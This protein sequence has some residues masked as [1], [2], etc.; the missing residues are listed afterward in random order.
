MHCYGCLQIRG[1]K[2]STRVDSLLGPLHMY[3]PEE[4][5]TVSDLLGN[6]ILYDRTCK[7]FAGKN[8]KYTVDLPELVMISL[9]S[10]V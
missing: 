10:K 6:V 1:K 2:L 5:Q 3:F 7:V 8:N 9:E 4:S